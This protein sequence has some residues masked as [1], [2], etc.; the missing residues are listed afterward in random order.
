VLLTPLLAV[1]LIRHS[2]VRKIRLTTIIVGV[3]LVA[4]LAQGIS[5]Y[6]SNPTA[7]LGT[8]QNTLAVNTIEPLDTP[9]WIT[10]QV[11]AQVPGKVPYQHG[12]TYLDATVRLLPGPIARAV[13]GSPTGTG[14]FFFKNDILHDTSTNQGYS[15]SFPS[16]AYLNFG[17]AGAFLVAVLLG[18]L[19][20]WAWR[21]YP[22]RPTRTNDLLYPILIATLPY[23]WR[24]DFLTQAKDVIYPLI[25]LWGLFAV[26]SRRMSPASEPSPLATV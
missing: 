10:A 20:G 18:L 24:S 16:E 17:P 5:E 26:C 3:V 6:R 23:G 15:F 22:E 1:V 7:R 11:A 9:A 2:A 25:I 19:L 13:F 14:A 21:R 12:R 8:K 4:Y